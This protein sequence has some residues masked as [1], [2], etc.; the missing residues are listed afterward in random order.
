MTSAMMD[1]LLKLAAEKGIKNTEAL[2]TR[3]KN[4]IKTLFKAYVGRN[5][6]DDAGFYP[7]YQDI[8]PI[9]LKAIAL[10]KEK[11]NS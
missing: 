5:I 6:F 11:S 3:A 4:N 10:M 1:E 9:L 7:I 2:S 8:D